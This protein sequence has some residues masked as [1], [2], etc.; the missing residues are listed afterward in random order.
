[1]GGWHTDHRRNRTI[2]ECVAAILDRQV[3]GHRA[4]R[5]D[6]IELDAA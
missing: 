3:P 1:M 6:P 4:I 2:N 5:A